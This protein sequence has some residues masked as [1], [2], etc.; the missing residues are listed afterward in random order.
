VSGA[1]STAPWAGNVRAPAPADADAAA[2]LMAAYHS[3]HGVPE[4]MTA[5]DLRR[6]WDELDLERDA[7][8]LELDGELVGYA[9]V[10]GRRSDRLNVDGYVHPD[11]R[12]RGVGTEILRLAEARARERG[13]TRLHE[14][15]LHGDED[16][17]RLFEANGYAF[18]RAFLRM[19]IAL[20]GPPPE[21]RVPEG[22]TLV[23][24]DHVDE[25]AVHAATQEGFEDHWE[26]EPQDY[27]AWAR[28]HAKSDRSLWWVIE[29]DGE[30]VAAS[31]NEWKHEGAGWIG[32]L[33]TRRAWRGRG[34]AQALLHASF[35]E[36]YRRGERT[37]ALGV[38]ASN[39][40]GAVRLYQRVGMSVVW[41]ADLFEKSLA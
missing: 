27:E 18:V 35:G 1:G 5:D 9:C 32:T 28:R 24:G 7:W 38:D 15:T 21:P 8:L 39:P 10:Y 19:A 36:F 40:T 25:R 6:E 17:R 37:V 2:A 23:R 30:V 13:A 14:G 3:S 41:R 11:R 31:V 26:H 22:L 16:A 29:D 12:G 33:A 34:V 20:D 4:G